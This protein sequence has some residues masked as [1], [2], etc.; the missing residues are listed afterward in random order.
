MLRDILTAIIKAL[1]WFVGWPRPVLTA[2][3][4]MGDVVWYKID[5]IFSEIESRAGKGYIAAV[6]I[7]RGTGKVNYLV[8]TEFSGF[9]AVWR[10]ENDLQPYI[11]A[12]KGA[13]ENE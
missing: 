9:H 11:E 5:T 13:D 10:E 2:Q 1:K 12:D 6:K 3:F 4:S 7:N 8:K